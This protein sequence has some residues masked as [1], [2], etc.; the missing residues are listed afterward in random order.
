MIIFRNYKWIIFLI[1]AF[2]PFPT[3]M[4]D[5][6]LP[7]FRR[8]E[9]LNA[10]V[11]R[12]EPMPVNDASIVKRLLEAYQ[13]SENEESR[14]NSMWSLFFTDRHAEIHKIFKTGQI[15]A[16]AAILRN[17]GST[18][19]FYGID[20]LTATT[21]APILKDG[22]HAVSLAI[23][24]LDN[25]VRFGEAIG[26]VR[27]DYPE[28]YYYASPKIW[29][30]EAIVD[31]IES[32]I[33]KKLNFPNPYPDEFGVWTPRGVVS[34][35]V[36]QALYQAWR[37]KQL[38]KDIPNPRVLEIG[39]GLGR[40]AYYAK[41][42]GIENYTI[43]DLPLT[44]VCSGY[45][46]ARTLGED[47]VVFHGEPALDAEN[48]VKILTPADFLQDQ[49]NYD[50]IVNVDSFTEMDPNIA[51]AY[52]NHIQASTKLFLSINHEF[53]SFTV[54]GLIDGSSYVEDSIRMP[55]WMRNGYVEE[56]VRFK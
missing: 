39:A 49:N 3:K 43:V 36:P 9:A 2:L 25:L 1:A 16:A 42:L 20:N 46:L 14:G 33:G 40:T 22:R 12:T 34:Y 18:D 37:I 35:R 56:V 41:L 55:Y 19:L 31:A 7:L 11:C 8:Q 45:F 29:T 10:L 5:A 26:A 28:S 13:R 6:N 54:K 4:L 30:A 27:L 24:C 48:K 44:G 21:Q 32:F 38:L 50:I 15:D 52:W 47:K 23:V 17:P 53:N 51:R